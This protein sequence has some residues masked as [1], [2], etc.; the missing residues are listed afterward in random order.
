MEPLP[1]CFALPRKSGPEIVSGLFGSIV[2]VFGILLPLRRC[3]RAYK[4]IA[5]LLDDG[6]VTLS[7]IEN[8]AED[9]SAFVDVHAIGV[10]ACGEIS[11]R[12]KSVGAEFPHTD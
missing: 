2:L 11:E 7:K 8:R 4:N 12:I 5:P 9:I 3:Y 6:R 1:P 10:V